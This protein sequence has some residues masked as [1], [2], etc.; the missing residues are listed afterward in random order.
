MLLLSPQ[1]TESASPLLLRKSELYSSLPFPFV[2]KLGKRSREL[3]RNKR[4]AGKGSVVERIWSFPYLFIFL[5]AE[6]AL[7]I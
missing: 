4:G 1:R 2:A 6:Q 3:S 7:P 5:S